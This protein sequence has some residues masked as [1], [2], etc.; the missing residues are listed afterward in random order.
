MKSKEAAN[1]ASECI[2][3]YYNLGFIG[4]LTS[5]LLGL[6]RFMH[7]TQSYARKIMRAIDCIAY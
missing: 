3:T 5:L 4:L 2:V 1:V 7:V 6:V